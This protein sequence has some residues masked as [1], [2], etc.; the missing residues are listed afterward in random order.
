[1]TTEYESTVEGT[2]GESDKD[3]NF[4][5]LETKTKAQEAELKEL[6]PLRERE[7]LRDAG[8]DPDS[9]RGKAITNA[10]KVRR[11]DGVEI[12]LT[13]EGIQELAV[14]EYGY[15]PQPLLTPDEAQ[16]QQTQSRVDSLRT[17]SEPDREVTLDD[18]I[19]EAEAEGNW[20]K[21]GMLKLQ[22]YSSTL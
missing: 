2:E 5:V 11:A 20:G 6:R 16:R 15:K 7:A 1:M 9:D 3:R 14:T 4:R 18:Q 17:S 12:D 21:S 10:I 8:F 22:K 13:A 19:A